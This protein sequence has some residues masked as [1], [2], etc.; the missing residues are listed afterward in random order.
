MVPA[1]AALTHA[2]WYV[3]TR[4]GLTEAG[5]HGG[6]PAGTGFHVHPVMSPEPRAAVSWY[7]NS[8]DAGGAWDKPSGQLLALQR[9]LLAAGF[10]VEEAVDAGSVYLLAW[11]VAR[12]GA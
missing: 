5:H 2:I 9:A 4:A 7:E 6:R 10:Q 3:L 8:R 1:D 12:S 11:R